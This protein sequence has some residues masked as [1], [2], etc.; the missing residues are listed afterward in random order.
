MY[1]LWNP[2]VQSTKFG[3]NFQSA[4][5]TLL[6]CQRRWESPFSLLPD[7]AVFYILN[8]CRW[9]WFHDNS[10]TM[11]DRRKREKLRK[12]LLAAN[13][14]ET[15]SS[16]HAMGCS[17]KGEENE[18]SK[19]R[20]SDAVSSRLRC[21][22]STCSSGDMTAGKTTGLND[23]D[24]EDE[25]N[26]VMSDVEGNECESDASSDDTMNSDDGDFELDESVDESSDDDDDDDYHRANRRYFS[27]QHPDSDDEQTD[28]PTS[29]SLRA[30]W[31]RHQF[32]RVH[33]L[34]ALASLED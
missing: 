1:K 24:E 30:D 31:F 26:V 27:F 32:A 22:Q 7:E 6:L 21:N 11:K 3:C 19:P 13:Q 17:A 8:M 12:Q 23:S 16:M 5:R 34:Q 33:V 20:A 25:E 15:A 2:E 29:N 4:V 14:Q 10:K 18:D 9:D 28:K